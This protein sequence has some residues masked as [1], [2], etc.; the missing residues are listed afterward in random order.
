MLF[1]G[2]VGPNLHGNEK[3]PP[4]MSARAPAGSANKNI[5]TDVAI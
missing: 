1:G 3:T 4:V 5:G 2:G